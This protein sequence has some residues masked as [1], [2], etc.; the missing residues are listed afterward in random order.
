[1]ASLRMRGRLLHRASAHRHR[2]VSMFAAIPSRAY[3]QLKSIKPREISAD[4]PRTAPSAEPDFIAQAGQFA[5]QCRSSWLYSVLGRYLRCDDREIL[6]HVFKRI[7]TQSAP[8][9]TYISPIHPVAAYVRLLAMPVYFLLRRKIVW[10]RGAAVDFTLETI[11]PPYFQRWFSTIYERVRGVKQ[12]TPFS[13]GAFETDHI[14]DPLDSFAYYRDLLW[15]F[16][17]C[18]LSLIPLYRLSRRTGLSLTAAYVNTLNVYRK[19]DGYF[20]RYPCRIFL[21]YSDD[22][23]HPCRYLAFHQNSEG[24]LIVVQNGERIYHPQYAFGM[25]DRYLVF[26]RAYAQ[27]LEKL[28]V[29]ANEFRPVGALCLNEQFTRVLDA[30]RNGVGEWYNILFIDQSFYPFNGLS[31]KSSDSIETIL[32]N[33]RKFHDCHSGIRIAYQL[34]SYASDLRQKAEVVRRVRDL[35]S[36]NITILEN[37]GKGE[38]YVNALR[39]E[40]VITFESTFGFEAM[41]MGR[42][43]LFV[44]YSGDR[45]ETLCPDVRFQ[46]EDEGGDYALFE[47]RIEELAAMNLDEIPEVALERHFAFD[48]RVQERIADVLAEVMV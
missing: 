26:G 14:T 27:I 46:I 25:V 34:R 19:F 20:K 43:V 2:F 31:K 38:T 36:G 21:T 39:S 11:D 28:K 10:R 23:N 22:F 12:I 15:L 13:G 35:F 30:S 8:E 33:I 44:N 7:Y 1:M 41:R 37:E 9:N 6:D 18:P 42:K 3:R 5:V 48:G 47:K 17:V 40:L 16:V 24:E 4:A 29:R 32:R 45:A